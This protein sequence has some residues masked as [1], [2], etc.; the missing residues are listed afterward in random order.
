MRLSSGKWDG[1]FQPGLSA[2]TA[3]SKDSKNMEEDIMSTLK[4]LVSEKEKELTASPKKEHKC[5]PARKVRTG[6]GKNDYILQKLTEKEL[7][8]SVVKDSKPAV[9]TFSFLTIKI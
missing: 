3:V 8:G 9:N 5:I 7:A 4:S 6:P 2:P 1:S